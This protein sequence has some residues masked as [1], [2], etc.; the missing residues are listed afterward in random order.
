M[1]VYRITNHPELDGEGAARQ[2]NNRWNSLGTRMVYCSGSIALAKGEISR[3]T[4]L[5]LLPKSFQILHIELPEG[6]V[7]SPYDYP[8]NWDDVPPGADS[9]EFGDQFILKAKYLALKVPSVFDKMSFNYLLN[10]LHSDFKRV[11]VVKS[12][13]LYI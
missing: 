8:E 1:I 5:A 6:A 4:P 2:L 13:P 10:P 12:E 7:S 11:M 3:R 9:K